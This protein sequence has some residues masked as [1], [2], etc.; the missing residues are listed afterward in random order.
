MNEA[1]FE[2]FLKRGGRS[3][4][5]I[6]RCLRMVGQFEEYLQQHRG[7]KCLADEEPE[8]LEAFVAWIE[9]ELKASAK[10]HLWALGY[11]FEFN[12]DQELRQLAGLLRE[13]RIRRNPFPLKDFRGVDAE[14]AARLEATGIRNVQQM[15]EAGRTQ[16]GRQKLADETGIP[17]AAIVELV[18]LS[19]LAH[20]PGIKGIR[21]RLYHDAGV[22]TVEKMAGWDPEELRAML[23][24]FVERTGF[25]GIA[26]LPAE[27]TFSV[28]R[29]KELPK[30]V[31]Y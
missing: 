9:G 12:Q 3:L 8:D 23:L 5:A 24:E 22:D 10:T 7:G 19:D 11:W 13:Q 25:E 6:Q 26:P 21:A 30:I 29:A 15:I 2:K 31:E 16:A 4:N 27:A 1:A 17:L 28:A 14:H 18:K 20:I